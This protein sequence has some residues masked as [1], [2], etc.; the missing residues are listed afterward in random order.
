MDQNL[1]ELE[2]WNYFAK[3]GFPDDFSDKNSNVKYGFKKMCEKFGK[4]Y[5]DYLKAA[6]AAWN[7]RC[8]TEEKEFRKSMF[9]ARAMAHFGTPEIKKEAEEL[10]E[11]KWAEK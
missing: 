5:I 4:S 2:R 6:W 1:D 7:T 9:I 11:K 10:F 3:N 8:G